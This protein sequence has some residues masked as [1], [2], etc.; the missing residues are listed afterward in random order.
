MFHI[1]AWPDAKVQHLKA[2]WDRGLSASKIA[3]EMGVTR[4]TVI[5]KASRLGWTRA[6]APP[7]PEEI[8]AQIEKRRARQKL[9][10]R[11][12]ERPITYRLRVFITSQPYAETK[13]MEY[14]EP[15]NLTLADLTMK[16]GRPV[17]CRFITN[18]DLANATY[19]AHPVDSET[20]WCRHHRLRLQ[21]PKGWIAP[22]M[23]PKIAVAA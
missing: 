15:L 18:D 21:P 17:E 9:Y 8:Q 20:S 6:K 12:R 23:A 19:C 1:G 22:A 7:T 4:N 14:R 5:G 16:D 13:T 10:E 2:L 11:K 3:A